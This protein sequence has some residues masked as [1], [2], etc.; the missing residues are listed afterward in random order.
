MKL[1]EDDVEWVVNDSAELGVK[2]GNQ[3][4][5]LYKGRSFQYSGL[6]DDGTLM[7]YRP[8]FKREFGESCLPWDAIE[9]KQYGDIKHTR[10][11]NQPESYVNFLEGEDEPEMWTDLP[12]AQVDE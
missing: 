10:P 8:V 7:K 6:K 12:R 2:I 9:R 11:V 3:V 1:K 4:F 5:F